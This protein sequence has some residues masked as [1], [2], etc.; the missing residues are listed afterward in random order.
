MFEAWKGRKE[1]QR[2]NREEI[3]AQNW[4]REIWMFW[5]DKPDG[6]V[7]LC[8]SNPI[9]DKDFI[10]FEQIFLF[11]CKRVTSYCLQIHRSRSIDGNTNWIYTILL[12]PSFVLVFLLVF[13]FLQ[14]DVI[15][16]ATTPWLCF[17]L[18]PPSSRYCLA[19]GRAPPSMPIAPLIAARIDKIG[20]SSFWNWVVRFV[21]SWAGASGSLYD[22]CAN[23]FWQLCW[24]IDYFNHE[25]NEIQ[26]PIDLTST[27]TTSSS[28]HSTTCR[29]RIARRSKAITRRWMRSSCRLTRWQCRDSSKR[30]Q[31]WS[32]FASLR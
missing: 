2:A 27:R 18:H 32:T 6:P 22:L 30:M 14:L 16:A 13:I 23:T 11:L 4:S 17:G 19:E 3:E 31:Q 28:L 1:Q 21:Q 5:F 20:R 26:A 25:E 9:R 7:F 24:G 12:N 29:R 10:C 15:V 8:R